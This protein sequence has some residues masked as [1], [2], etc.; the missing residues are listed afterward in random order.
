MF[1]QQSPNQEKSNLQ[2]CHDLVTDR[3]SFIINVSFPPS[4]PSSNLDAWSVALT[5]LDGWKKVGVEDLYASSLQTLQHIEAHEKTFIDVFLRL[6]QVFFTLV[7]LPIFDLPVIQKFS[8]TESPLGKYQLEISVPAIEG[9]ALPVYEKTLSI[10]LDVCTW[11]I[12]YP[13]TLP[14][15][16]Y[17]FDTVEHKLTKPLIPFV[18][19]GKST[20]PTLRVAH[21]LDIPFFHLGLGIYQ[22]GWG[23][24]AV[25]LDRSTTLQDSA[26]SVR[27]TQSKV[28]TANVLKM[29]GLPAAVHISVS[30]VQE[31]YKAAEQ[32]G[33][34][35]VVK[36][37]DQERGEGVTVDIRDNEALKTAFFSACDK[38]PSRQV[39]VERQ[40]AGV[41]HRIFIVGKQLLYAVKRLPI[42]VQGDGV[43][44]IE[45]LVVDH[46]AAQTLTAPWLRKDA[47]S[48]DDLARA[49]LA[50]A[51]LTEASVPLAGTWVPLRPIESTAWGGV[52][53]DV[54]IHIHP[55]NISAALT[56]AARFGL[57]TAGVDM[58]SADITQPWYENGAIIN[59]VNFAPLLGGAEI[60]RSYLPAFFAQLIHGDGRI[61]IE[62]VD[63]L[64]AAMER[65]ESF[66]I[67]G[68]RC[69]VTTPFQTFDATGNLLALPFDGL[70]QRCMALIYRSEVDAIVLVPE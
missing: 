61:P 13:A 62:Y 19:A 45:Q 34:P 55:E 31:A 70:K 35:V 10:A 50:K 68:L 23:S 39:L 2:F 63:H 28:S 20:I 51:N 7:R 5:G 58:I 25:L 29:A 36:P 1:T 37:I 38:T 46:A 21:E 33:F 6:S 12:K 17:I 47:Q 40:V 49:T 14:N 32:I 8:K 26:I 41:C 64:K 60:S 57:H 30:T 66:K 44:S 11:I 54:T 3:L 24:Q 15:K 67:K 65:Q 9:I 59:E 56:A 4:V 27:L 53:E 42:S 48:L 16:K 69:F 18:P 43:K 22:L 52:D